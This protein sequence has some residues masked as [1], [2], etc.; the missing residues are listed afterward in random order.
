[1]CIT[2]PLVSRLLT[3]IKNLQNILSKDGIIKK[4]MPLMDRSGLNIGK[5]VF[6]LL[7]C[8]L[9]NANRNIQVRFGQKGI[10]FVTGLNCTKR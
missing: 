4:V 3:K 6:C 10:T 2:F 9:F 8:L 5:E 1:M 7:N